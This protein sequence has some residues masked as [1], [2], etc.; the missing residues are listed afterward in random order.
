MSPVAPNK[1]KPISFGALMATTANMV[2]PATIW[3]QSFVKASRH[4]TA[5]LS[6]S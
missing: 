5:W 3:G 1:A 6:R 2:Q 4:G